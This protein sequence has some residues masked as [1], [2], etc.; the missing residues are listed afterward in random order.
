MPTTERLAPTPMVPG[1]AGTFRRRTQDFTT[2]KVH[3]GESRNFRKGAEP[4]DLGNG[5]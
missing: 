4:G 2:E 1:T 5:S 3:G